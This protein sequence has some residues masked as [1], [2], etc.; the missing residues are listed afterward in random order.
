MRIIVSLAAALSLSMVQPLAA[1]APAAPASINSG[2]A[3]SQTEKEAA[4][5]RTR[6]EAK[7]RAWDER[8]K[9]TMRSICSGATGC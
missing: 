9:R 4:Q 8:M 6:R 3:V 7:E 1:Q 2:A 5:A